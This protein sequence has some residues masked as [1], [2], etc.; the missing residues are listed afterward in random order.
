MHRI[1]RGSALPLTRSRPLP[2]TALS[3][4]LARHAVRWLSHK[5]S[6]GMPQPFFLFVFLLFLP[7]SL[8]PSFLFC[9]YIPSYTHIS[10]SSI[11]LFIFPLFVISF[12]F[13]HLSTDLAFQIIINSPFLVKI[14]SHSKHIL[15]CSQV[16]DSLK[17][18]NFPKK[19]KI[20]TWLR[21]II[22]SS[23]ED[24]LRKFLV[25]VT[26]SPSITPTTYQKIEINVRCQARSG[27]L[28]VA[29]TCFYHLGKCI[30]WW[31]GWIWWILDDDDDFSLY[32]RLISW[33]YLCMICAMNVSNKFDD[34]VFGNSFKI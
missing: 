2:F 6:S 30:L 29:H 22:L 14:W 27:S 10:H 19:S 15:I 28:P 7:S 24:H 25:F 11:P 18:L 3:H 1:H 33:R 4:G 31:I 23:S 21:E 5:W 13:F 26:G 32:V 16:N 8:L 9:F 34:D 20:P 17:F 12:F